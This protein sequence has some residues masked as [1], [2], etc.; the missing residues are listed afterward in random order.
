MAI[1][2][3]GERVSISVDHL[4]QVLLEIV[5]GIDRQR[6]IVDR[7]AVGDHHQDAALLG[8]AEQAVM[9]PQQRL[10]VDVL[11][12]DALAQHQA[13]VLAGAPPR[14][15]GR[16]VDDVAQIVEPAGIGRLAGGDPALARLAALPRP[17]GE[18]EDLDLDAAALQ[19]ARQDVGAHRGDG[20]RPAAHRAGIVD[21]QGHHRVAELGVLLPLVGQRQHRVDDDARQPRRVEHA[22]LEVE[23]PGAGLL[24]PAAGAAAGWPAAPT[25]PCRC[26]SCWS[27]SWR[28]RVS[29]SASHSSSASTTSSNC[30]GEGADRRRLVAAR[31]AASAAA[32]RDGPA[33]RRLRRRHPSRR[34][35]RSSP[36][37][38][39]SPSALSA[40]A[41]SIA[42]CGAGAGRSRRSRL[43]LP[44]VVLLPCV[45]RCRRR[46]LVELVAPARAAGPG[47]AGAPRVAIGVLVARCVRLSSAMSSPTRLPRAT[48]RQSIDHW[49]ARERR[50]RS[51]VSASR[52]S[53]RT[54]SASGRLVALGD[55]GD[56]PAAGSARRAPRV[57]L[58]RDAGHASGADRLDARLL[59]RVEDCA[60]E[61]RPAA[62]RL[63]C[64]RRVVVAQ[65]SARC[66]VG[67]AA[68]AGAHLVGAAGSRG[69]SGS[70]A[71]ASPR[72]AGWPPIGA[73]S[74][75]RSTIVA[76]A[77]TIARMALA[78]GELR[79]NLLERGLA[80]VAGRTRLGAVRRSIARLTAGSPAARCRSSAGS[81]R[82]PSAAR[83][84][85]TC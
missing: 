63:A 23:L 29:S 5:A 37:S 75:A 73:R 28:S 46:R 40:A 2:S 30:G 43:A 77:P 51:P 78:R 38:S 84:R 85:R 3:T 18:A 80:G 72:S 60:R 61:R 15:V 83:P 27:S 70:R 10:A 11:L 58:L 6:R 52:A 48:A 54:T 14:R 56:S 57:R 76:L 39:A 49:R 79:R 67:L 32:G 41:P 20:D 31:R 16:L 44:S 8:P 42:S 64:M 7:R 47:S 25:T 71:L 74:R 50:R 33:R 36:S 26:D 13:E 66:A 21:Q 4:A 34:R 24:A 82:P 65:P 35:P 22:F 68:R 45:L 59:E 62:L 19:R 9:R 12:E 81:T 69:G 55:A 53:R 17:R 1:S